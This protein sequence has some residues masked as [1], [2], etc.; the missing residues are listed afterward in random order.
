M[1]K[2][3]LIVSLILFLSS[4]IF[5]LLE[6]HFVNVGQ[7]DAA[8]INCDGHWGIIDGADTKGAQMLFSYINDVCKVPSF[9]LVVLSHSDKDHVGGMRGAIQDKLTNNSIVWFDEDS[10]NT[11]RWFTSFKEYVNSCKCKETKKPDL[12]QQYQLG[13]CLITVIGPTSDFGD[14]NNNS[15]II[16]I[17]Y[18]GKSFIFMGDAEWKAQNGL[19]N[20]YVTANADLG[21]FNYSPMLNCDVLKVA[22]HGGSIDEGTETTVSYTLLRSMHPKFAVISV[23]IE[24]RYSHPHPNTLSRLIQSEC[25]IFRTDYHGTIVFA[26]N[27]SGILSLKTEKQ[28][29]NPWMDESL[30]PSVKRNNTN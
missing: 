30:L 12:G 5:A 11:S 16:R 9:D 20:E 4:P 1:T 21:F 15:I 24:N 14:R 18:K 8:L 27:D 6:V 13:G 10:S 26:V 17:D 22:H 19:I 28:N 3:L 25:N 2:R 23:G 29:G 7:G